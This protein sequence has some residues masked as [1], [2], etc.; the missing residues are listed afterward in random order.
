M[1]CCGS[2]F[3]AHR[4]SLSI[5]CS[6][7]LTLYPVSAISTKSLYTFLLSKNLSTTHCV[8]KFAPIFGPLYWSCTWRQLFLFDMDRPVIDLAWKIAHGVLYTAD[9]LASFSYSLELSCFCNSAFEAIDH[10][11][12][13]CPL[14]H[15]V[16]S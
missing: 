9:R 5:G 12:F 13:E 14:A 15:S 10:L 8:V 2:G 11:F 6:S 4:G 7:G 3:S 1:A 16:L